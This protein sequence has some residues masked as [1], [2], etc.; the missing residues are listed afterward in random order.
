MKNKEK[1]Q[2][3]QK[4]PEVKIHIVKESIDIDN[5]HALPADCATHAKKV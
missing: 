1:K 3:S 5:P 2:A 4:K